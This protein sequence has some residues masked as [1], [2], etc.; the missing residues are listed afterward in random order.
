MN[1][2]DRHAGFFYQTKWKKNEKIQ[3]RI[4]FF[5]RVFSMEIKQIHSVYTFQS[6]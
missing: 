6:T 2:L 5:F 4:L 1:N 3:Q